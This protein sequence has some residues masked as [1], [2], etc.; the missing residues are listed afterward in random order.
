MAKDLWAK[1]GEDAWKEPLPQSPGVQKD[2]VQNSSAE[3]QGI[4]KYCGP[5]NWLSQDKKWEPQKK[6][7]KC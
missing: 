1:C 4:G 7:S 5:Q 3:G 6:H 2:F